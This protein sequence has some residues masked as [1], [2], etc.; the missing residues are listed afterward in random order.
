L[1]KLKALVVLTMIQK[2]LSL[3]SASGL[4][5][6]GWCGRLARVTA[7]AHRPADGVYVYTDLPD[8]LSRDEFALISLSAEPNTRRF[9]EITAINRSLKLQIPLAISSETNFALQIFCTRTFT[10]DEPDQR[11][12]S[13][14]LREIGL[15]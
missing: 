3:V 6:D 13:F 5:E 4:Y 11:E 1:N 7:R 9:G 12:L 8:N 14:Q 15:I 10:P 2:D